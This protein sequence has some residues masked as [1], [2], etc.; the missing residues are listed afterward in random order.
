MMGGMD[1]RL[2]L[3]INIVSAI[4][5]ID[6]M[7]QGFIRKYTGWRGRTYMFLGCIVYFVTVTWLNSKSEFEGMLGLAYCLVLI[8]YGGIALQGRLRDK[9]IMGTLWMV[10]A[11]LSA[12]V[13]FSILGIVTGKD[14]VKLLQTNGDV[15]VYSALA[16]AILKFTLGRMAASIIKRIRGRSTG[17]EELV[18][19]GAFLIIF[20]L[21][22]GI[23]TLERGML[24]QRE[25]YYLS[26]WI[27]GS[28]L[29]ILVCLTYFYHCL[30]ERNQVERAM[31]YTGGRLE[32]QK[33]QME[34]LERVCRELHMIKHDMTGYFNVLQSL[35]EKGKEEEALK[36]IEEMKGNIKTIAVILK[37]TGN[38]GL[39]A[40]IMNALQEC[41]ERNIQ[42]RYVVSA[43]VKKIDVMDMGILFYNLF[44][45]AVE[46]CD[47]AERNKIVEIQVVEEKNGM[48]C[49]LCNT[50]KV[51]LLK[52]NPNLKTSK[53]DSRNH[54]YGMSSIRNIIHKYDGSYEY[55]EEEN[56]FVQEIRMKYPQ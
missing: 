48:L 39:D 50:I 36:Y 33:E 26:L 7:E 27:I 55:F 56:M 2:C 17:L 9:I 11:L 12:Y 37:E 30:C 42:F 25:R 41:R 49:T 44:S 52:N 6:F 16:T 8:V 1:E 53:K 45:N 19:I 32:Q 3:L 15:R 21:V 5:A 18:I 29:G 20:I 40:S 46:A 23:F 13:M 28:F 14:L 38:T 54:G 4:I 35:L 24:N 34:G 43:D 31:A 22:V 51:P 10:I 47:E